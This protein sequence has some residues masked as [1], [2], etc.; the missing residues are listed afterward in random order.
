MFFFSEQKMFLNFVV[1]YSYSHK[2]DIWSRNQL[3]IVYEIVMQRWLDL[4]LNEFAGHF[5]NFNG[6]NHMRMLYG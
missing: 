2:I 3:Q 4:S 1:A 6:G 5:C